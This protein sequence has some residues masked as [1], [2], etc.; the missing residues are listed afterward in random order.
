M[1]LSVRPALSQSTN[2]RRPSG[3]LFGPTRS[4]TGAA[5]KLRFTFELAQGLDSEVPSESGVGVVGGGLGSGGFSTLFGASSTYAL[6]NRRLQLAGS[7]ST[8][9]KYYHQLDRLDALSHDAS[10]G[11]GLRLPKEGRLEINQAAAYSPSYLYQLF[12]QV[13]LPEL[14]PSIPSNPDY[15][16]DQEPSY[17]YS[18][19]TAI[20]FGSPSGTQ[21]TTSGEYHTTDYE[22]ATASRSDLDTRAVGS[23]V[24][25]ALSKSASLSLGYEYKT[26]EFDSERSDEHESTIGVHYSPVL[27]RSRRLTL[28]LNVAPTWLKAQ[29]GLA[30]PTLGG[31]SYT[32]ALQGDAHISYPFRP[33]WLATVSY[34]RDVQYLA[35]L[36]EPLFS[37]GTRAE[38][39]GLISRRIDVSTSA[40]YVTAT[41]AVPGVNENLDTY[42][43]TV[44]IRYGLKRSFALYSEYLYYYYDQR[45]QGS[46]VPDLP[47][48]FSQ[49]GVRLGVTVFVDA[50]GR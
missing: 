17:T 25:H 2:P 30:A 39:T 11:I 34:A 22:D 37:D 50:L 47:P 40:G 44:K 9:F 13:D 16:I 45:G 12:P 7:A 36:S 33:N 6:E 5:D 23:T 24:S 3:G 14:G 15:R 28:A 48:V 10:L 31:T 49:H 1:T 8:A 46:L 19:R 20:K 42:T 18:T 4:D 35:G 41:S 26:G 29:S 43:G 27:S 21:F 32:F 38:L